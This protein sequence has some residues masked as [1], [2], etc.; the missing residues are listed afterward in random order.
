MNR[1]RSRIQ[2]IEEKHTTFISSKQLAAIKI[3]R[4]A[5]LAH[6]GIS[7]ADYHAELACIDDAYSARDL[8]RL[9]TLLTEL[10]KDPH[11]RT[12]VQCYAAQKHFASF[13]N[14]WRLPN[15]HAK[16]ILG[17][18][19]SCERSSGKPKQVNESFSAVRTI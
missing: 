14:G 9:Q 17:P 19:G 8:K 11:G 7:L 12:V 4:E 13:P 18:H 6:Y 3:L 10:A 15:A 16:L 5:E 1:L 2:R